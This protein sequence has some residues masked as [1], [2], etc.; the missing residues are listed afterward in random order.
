MNE[1]LWCSVHCAKLLGTLLRNSKF[2]APAALE[3]LPLRSP[4]G[5]FVCILDASSS[6]LWLRS[7]LSLAFLALSTGA[8]L[9]KVLRYLG[10]NT[11][12]V[13]VTSRFFLLEAA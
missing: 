3:F 10:R 11:P 7:S 2:G 8:G 12:A 4:R 1:L 6:N 13:I 5:S 9:A